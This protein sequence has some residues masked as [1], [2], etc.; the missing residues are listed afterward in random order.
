MQLPSSPMRNN[1]DSPHLP[2]SSSAARTL[3]AT[4][5]EVR[6]SP[7]PPADDPVRHVLRSHQPIPGTASV[8][9]PMRPSLSL[10]L[11]ALS[12]SASSQEAPTKPLRSPHRL[13][14]PMPESPTGNL[15]HFP[16]DDP[17]G[18]TGEPM[19]PLSDAEQG[20]PFSSPKQPIRMASLS[21]PRRHTQ[22]TQTTTRTTSVSPE[23][24]A[25]PASASA[26][27]PPASTAPRPHSGP[28]PAT[29]T[30]SSSGG[31][32]TVP[33]P[34]SRP[35]HV[36]GLP[37]PPP[38]SPLR[39][40]ASLSLADTTD[41]GATASA[42]EGRFARPLSRPSLS[43]RSRVTIAGGSARGGAGL[44]PR[45][46]STSS[47]AS[48]GSSSLASGPSGTSISAASGGL[49]APHPRVVQVP[50][51]V[52]SALRVSSAAGSR[53]PPPPHTPAGAGAAAGGLG[54]VTPLQT[55]AVVV[56]VTAAGGRGVGSQTPLAIQPPLG[57]FFRGP[58][59]GSSG[60]LTGFVR[61]ARK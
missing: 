52:M 26:E 6:Y 61:P 8:K 32:A 46:L 31:P 17:E 2:P 38:P 13:L 19:T 54:M 56:G 44:M 41:T 49:A 12:S 57:A 34:M 22:P 15:H 45:R 7:Q 16:D 28:L 20:D 59:R 35:S 5:I 29:A 18:T 40:V 53:I 3:R 48:A 10:D 39:S 27:P 4:A 1:G 30:T 58:E 9:H 60:Y 50:S 14:P 51:R 11:S 23:P 21:P 24:A 47:Q 25:P 42:T 43:A 37:P 55:P 36:T 33:L